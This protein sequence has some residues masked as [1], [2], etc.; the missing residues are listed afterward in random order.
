MYRIARTAVVNNRLLILLGLTAFGALWAIL[1]HQRREDVLSSGVMA[2]WTFLCGVVVIN[3][4]GWQRCAVAVLGDGSER[5]QR[6]Q[7]LLSLVFVL[8]CGLRSV[9][10]RADV[11][12]MGLID[13]WLSSILVGRSV[14]TAA[15]LCFAA[16]WAQFLYRISRET[17]SRLGMNIARVLVP[18][19]VGAEICSWY[20]VLTTCYL[21]NV[22]E[23]STWALCTGM[24]LVGLLA[25]WARSRAARRPFVAAALVIGVLYF[26]FL[27]SVDVPMYF[28]RWQAD[29]ASG[30]EYLTLAQG[31]HDAWARRVVTFDWQEWRPE[32]PWMSFYFSVGVWWSLAL[33]HAPRLEPEAELALN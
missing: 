5:F 28:T 18:L 33:V 27:C 3:L 16:Q 15:E 12:R 11:Q 2:W 31:V 26:A 22:I 9:L 13:S 20:A 19:I 4:C 6:R 30:R 29:L 8:G 14:A 32:I 10:P 23:E 24:L 25:V 7:L 1:L 21:G 17:G